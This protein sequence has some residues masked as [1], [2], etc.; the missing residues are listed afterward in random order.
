M[1]TVD[2]KDES[3]FGKAQGMYN[4]VSYALLNQI[5]IATCYVC[6]PTS[7]ESQMPS[8]LAPC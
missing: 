1:V 7:I 4:L 3:T 6:H 2:S 5:A 8:R